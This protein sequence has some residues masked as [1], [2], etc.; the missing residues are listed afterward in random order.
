MKKIL[1][2][3]V[4]ALGF[5]SCS[6]DENLQSTTNTT[7]RSD[8]TGSAFTN[9][10]WYSNDWTEEISGNVTCTA[11]SNVTFKMVFSPGSTGN[12]SCTVIFNNS[13]YH[14]SSSANKDLTISL[15]EGV[16]DISL[17]L[18]RGNL[19]ESVNAIAK[20][21]ITKVSG[22]SIVGFPDGYGD[23][24]AQMYRFM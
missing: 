17:R 22:G 16:S 7:T 19:N 18:E 13:S 4:L 1:F 14:Y 11:T 15:P 6:E 9:I 8:G 24:V 2:L 3:L 20:M 10:K 5:I 21:I 12:V 23:L